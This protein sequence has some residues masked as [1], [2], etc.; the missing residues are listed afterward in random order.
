M[1]NMY[2]FF[3]YYNFQISLQQPT[4]KMPIYIYIYMNLFCTLVAIQLSFSYF[5][6][7]HQKENGEEKSRVSFDGIFDDG[8]SCWAVSSCIQGMLWNLLH[9][10]LYNTRN[11]SWFMCSQMLKGLH[12][13][14]KIAH[15]ESPRH[16]IFLQAWLCYF[17]VHQ[18]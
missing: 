4:I 11:H 10:L 2:I 8:A 18:S 13:P 17:L 5:L 7:L 1:L 3:S 16:R 15:S 12:F 14:T 6:L 9:H